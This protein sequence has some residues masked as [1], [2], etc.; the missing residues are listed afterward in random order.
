MTQYIHL[1][2]RQSLPLTAT[3]YFTVSK[4]MQELCTFFILDNLLMILQPDNPTEL[5]SKIYEM[6]SSAICNKWTSQATPAASQNQQPAAP[7]SSEP[8]EAEIVEEPVHSGQ[9]K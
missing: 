4:T 1:I 5:S 8:L 2:Q 6:M 3:N 7:V 9:Q